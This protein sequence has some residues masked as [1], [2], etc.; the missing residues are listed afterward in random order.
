MSSISI[1]QQVAVLIG[2]TLGLTGNYTVR[3]VPRWNI[4]GTEV[5]S[6][7]QAA[8]LMG[9]PED[10]AAHNI[11][12]CDGDVDPE[13]KQ[14]AVSHLEVK[15]VRHV[16]TTAGKRKYNQPI[17]AIIVADGRLPNLT[18]LS[19]MFRD[20]ETMKG[21][22]GT[23]YHVSKKPVN[24]KWIAVTDDDK[25]VARSTTQEGVYKAL[26]KKA[27]ASGAA[28]SGKR[29]VAPFKAGNRVTVTDGGS[30][31]VGQ[32][33]KVTRVSP[34]GMVS[35]TFDN[36]Y[37]GEFDPKHLSPVTAKSGKRPVDPA[38]QAEVDKFNAVMSKPENIAAVTTK[39]SKATLDR[40]KNLNAKITTLEKREE[41]SYRR[42]RDFGVV[43]QDPPVVRARAALNDA[44]RNVDIEYDAGTG[45]FYINDD[46]G[47][48][49]FRV[50][51]HGDPVYAESTD[52]NGSPKAPQFSEAQL[53]EFRYRWDTY[54]RYPPRSKEAL[55]LLYPNQAEAYWQGLKR[56]LSPQRAFTAARKLPKEGTNIGTGIVYGALRHDMSEWRKT[57]GG[58]GWEGKSHPF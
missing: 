50:N 25:V 33:G 24:G 35:V 10:V 49:R 40:A 55:R 29:S 9:V 27:A 19:P 22:N 48:H 5:K 43:A 15:V 52:A 13:L 36:G 34:S 54:N 30:M 6:V 42:N 44:L 12:E 4:D 45:N 3:R 11:L 8:V 32:S 28:K 51:K 58:K 23:R 53:N 31:K 41:A 18:G 2:D 26:D 21:A 1:D 38:V 47:I 14:D 46:N 57:Q 39:P 37:K 16:R 7:E 20:Y 56:G 17:G